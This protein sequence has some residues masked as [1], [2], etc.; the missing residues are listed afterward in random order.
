[1]F[2][3]TMRILAFIFP[4]L[5][6]ISCATESKPVNITVTSD[7]FIP[8]IIHDI[9]YRCNGQ[10]IENPEVI[11]DSVAGIYRQRLD[12]TDVGEYSVTL[13]TVFGTETIQTYSVISDSTLLV[14]NNLPFT[15]VGFISEDSMLKADTVQFVRVVKG[16]FQ[17]DLHKVT[18]V[19][20]GNGYDLSEFP[21]RSWSNVDY[22]MITA[23]EGAMM[24]HEFVESE[25]EIEQL[26]VDNAGKVMASTTRQYVFFRADSEV[27]SYYDGGAKWVSYP[28]VYIP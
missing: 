9:T 25:N 10:I 21:Q 4:A 16:C 15:S 7:E 28:D 18:L 1:M 22:R 8:G 27:Y 23:E 19:K 11:F 24:I 14:K 5:F 12:T 2:I 6:I 20:N 3:C 26:R 17:N 13:T